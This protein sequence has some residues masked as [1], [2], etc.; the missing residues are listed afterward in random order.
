MII[1]MMTFM[2]VKTRRCNPNAPLPLQRYRAEVLTV[3]EMGRVLYFRFW[4][5]R[6]VDEGGRMTQGQWYRIKTKYL[7]NTTTSRVLL[8]S[9]LTYPS[10]QLAYPWASYIAVWRIPWIFAYVL[11]RTWKPRSQKYWIFKMI[12]NINWGID[13]LCPKSLLL[14][15][16]N[17]SA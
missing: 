9:V 6:L 15:S 13:G 17:L 14:L 2:I 10:Q 1:L 5:E 7:N 4:N 3:E 8:C 11:E 12:G 16:A